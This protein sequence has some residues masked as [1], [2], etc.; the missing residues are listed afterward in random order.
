MPEDERDFDLIFKFYDRS[1]DG[2]IDYKELTKIF[3]ARGDDSE[4]SLAQ[5][6]A[7]YRRK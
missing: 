5:Q 7:D 6:T 2:R 4:P 3:S 1:S